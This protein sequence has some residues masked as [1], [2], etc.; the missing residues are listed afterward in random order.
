VAGLVYDARNQAFGLRAGGA[1]RG[2][3]E[4]EWVASLEPVEKL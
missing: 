3:G 4:A 2:P 1:V